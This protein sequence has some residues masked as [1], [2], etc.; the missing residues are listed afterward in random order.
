MRRRDFILG[1]G[2]AA[3]WPPTARAQQP[4]MPVVALVSAAAL[5]ETYIRYLAAFR[6]GLAESGYV[7]DKNVSIEYHWLEGRYDRLPALMTDLASRRVA[8]ISVPGG[9]AGATV[10]KAATTVIP[11]VFGVGDDAVKLGLVASL[12]RPGG[13]A[14]GINYFSNE[15][16]PRRLGL[17]SALVPA[18]KRLAVLVNPRN[19][20]G[21]ETTQRDVQDAART[22]KWPVDVHK[23]GT[24]D[25]IE[26]A[27]DAMENDGIDA[28]FIASDP[29]FNSRRYQLASLSMQHEI[30]ACYSDRDFVEAGGL[31]SY[32][33][34]VADMWHQVGAYTG[35]I[36]KGANP[37]DLPVAHATKFIFALNM[38]TAKAL[39]IKVPSITRAQANVVIE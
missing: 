8:V 25:E 39:N 1:V 27:F 7:E 19:P 28:L 33:T 5:D 35:R 31:M 10:A 20:V 32:G 21:S 36:V 14:T 26:A 23:A 22:L 34:D 30:A 11:I 15:A 38:K 37:V 18:A 16:V 2:A 3:V 13:N 6:N 4:A 17:L 9:S 29:Y 12:A 24:R